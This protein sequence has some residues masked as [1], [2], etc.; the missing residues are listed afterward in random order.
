M[1]TMVLIFLIFISLNIS[2][3]SIADTI[4]TEKIIDRA[5]SAIAEAE[6]SLS[7]IPQTSAEFDYIIKILGESSKD[8]DLA[9]NSFNEL[10]MCEEK[11]SNL[12]NPALADDYRKLHKITKQLADTHA[13]SVIVAASYIRLVA[14]ND[15]DQSEILK[16][17]ISEIE[18]IKQLVRDNAEYTKKIIAKKYQ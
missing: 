13:N 15:I 8:W 18:Q 3:K 7:L 17:S 2:Q 9:L 4:E 6:A 10:K 14:I 16:N 12:E 5:R 11:I 1:R